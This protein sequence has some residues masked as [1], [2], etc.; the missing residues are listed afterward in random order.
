[1][2]STGVQWKSVEW[3]NLC[4]LYLLAQE[5]RLTRPIL[6]DDLGRQQWRGRVQRD[7]ARMISDA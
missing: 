6:G 4:P 1:M 3:T 7:A 2:D 5:S